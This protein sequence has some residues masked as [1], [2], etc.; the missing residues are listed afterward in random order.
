MNGRRQRP[1]YG[2]LHLAP[3]LSELSKDWRAL[4]EPALRAGWRL[5][6]GQG[7]HIWLVS[8]DGGTIHVLDNVKHF[9]WA[10]WKRIRKALR[11]TGTVDIP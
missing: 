1:Q 11:D 6:R 5:E 8:P 7:R 9:R 4:A 3:E 2:K 10:N